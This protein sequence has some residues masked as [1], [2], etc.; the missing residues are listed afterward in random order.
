M[1]IANIV[2]EPSSDYHWSHISYTTR[3]RW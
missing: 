2:F 1:G 3:R